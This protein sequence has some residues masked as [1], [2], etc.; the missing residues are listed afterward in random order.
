[1]ARPAGPL[2]RG[3][4][5]RPGLRRHG[6]PP[7]AADRAALRRPESRLEIVAALRG[8]REPAGPRAA[9]GALEGQPAGRRGALGR[10]AG[11]SAGGP[12]CTTAWSAETACSRRSRSRSR[13]GG[14]LADGRGLRRAARGGHR[15]GPRP[16]PDDLRR[17]V[18]QQR[19]APGVPE[20]DH[21]ADL[22][23][24]PD[25]PAVDGRQEAAA[26]RGPR[27]RRRGRPDDRR[28]VDDR[29][30]DLRHARPRRGGRRPCTSATA[31]A[32]PAGSATG[33]GFNAY[34]AAD[35]D[36]PG[37]SPGSRS[38]PDGS[39][40]RAGL[41]PAAAVDRGPRPDPRGDAGAVPGARP[42]SPTPTG[43]TRPRHGE[44]TPSLYPSY[45]YSADRGEGWNG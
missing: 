1:M 10:G 17:P 23:Q 4:G 43:T 38:T 41:D 2:P 44:L 39:D 29:R 20:A 33:I 36:T 31:A 24:R 32:G 28:T 13:A 7:A 11:P 18:R 37:S 5:R 12:A 27:D 21:Q 34:A 19:L 9:R 42:T 3:L 45:D 25:G 14:E 8:V 22:G 6:D 40:V 35:L 15:A 30:A 16:R 26:A